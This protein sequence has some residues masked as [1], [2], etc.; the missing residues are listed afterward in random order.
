MPSSFRLLFIWTP[1]MSAMVG[2]QSETCISS[3]LITPFCWISGLVTKLMPRTP[4][5]HS[6]CLYPLNGQLLPPASTSPPLSVH[7]KNFKLLLHIEIK[8]VVECQ[9]LPVISQRGIKF[10][11]RLNQSFVS[12]LPL[13][14]MENFSQISFPTTGSPKE[15]GS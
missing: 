9:K 12:W 13:G 11:Y 8:C 5:S 6:V 4:P 3:S 10:N 15:I 14:R 7:L 1:I 2:N